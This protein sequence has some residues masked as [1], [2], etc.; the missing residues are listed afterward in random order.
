MKLLDLVNIYIE[1]K[2]SIG[3]RF[4]SQPRVLQRFCRIM[5]DID[6][7][8]VRPGA[9]ETFLY[10]NKPLTNTWY[11]N[12]KLLHG[13]YR[14]A[15]SRGFA[16]T[17]PL[18]TVLPPP[19]PSFRPHIYS[20]KELTALLAATP[21]LHSIRNPLQVVTFRTL[22][23]LLYSTGMRIGEALSLTL[24]DV[25]LRSRL[26]TVR[27]S[28]FFKTRLVPVGPRLTKELMIYVERRRQLPL[29]QREDSAF[30]ASS[31]GRGLPYQH[32]ITLFQR[33]RKAAGI[34]RDRG[35]SYPPR[36]HD[37]RHTAAVHRVVAWYREGADVQRLL[38]QLATYLGHKDIRGT[39]RYLTMTPE[40]LQ[41]ASVC[42]EGY[43]KPEELHE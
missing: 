6:V 37:L 38:P 23:L 25:E 18:P 17:S 34:Q 21:V 4:G 16:A 20:V 24:Q 29:P 35:S 32:V 9:V 15:I 10:N 2:R 22:L 40:L 36:L 42:F 27:D 28:K 39:Q 13:L 30:F 7:S 26:L 31:T 1:F 43:A 33:V 5:G 14:F 41:Q 11:L 12:F 19:L 8:E 3:M